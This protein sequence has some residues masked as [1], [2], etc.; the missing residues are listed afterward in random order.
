MRG[1]QFSTLIARTVALILLIV[2]IGFFPLNLQAIAASPY[3]GKP[4]NIESIKNR[5]LDALFIVN[6][7]GKTDLAFAGNYTLSQSSKDD[8]YESLLITSR[9]YLNQCYYDSISSRTLKL[10]IENRGKTYKGTCWGFGVEYVDMATIATP[11]KS[12]T[13][14]LW[15]S[16]MPNPGGWLIAVYYVPGFG[17]TFKETAV[18]IINKKTFVIG[19]EK[20]SPAPTG[21]ALVFNQD[22]SF[23]GVLTSKGVGTVPA[24]YF[25]VHGSPLQCSPASTEGS[26]ITNCSTRKSINES[27]QDGVWTIDETITTTPTPTPVAT[28]RPS[29]SPTN[30]IADAIVEARDA[31][32]SALNAYKLYTAKVVACLEAFKGRNASERRMLTIVAGTQICSSENS[33]A[34]TANDQTLSLGQTISSSR[35]PLGLIT[36]FNNFTDTFNISAMAMDDAISMAN[37]LASLYTDFEGLENSLLVF[38]EQLENLDYVLSNLPTRVTALIKKGIAFDYVEENRALVEE[39]ES[40]F[41]EAQSEINGITYP[42]PEAIDDFSDSLKV[43]VRGLPS[44]TTFSRTLQRA[45]DSIPAFYCKKGTSATLPKKGKCASGFSRVKIDKG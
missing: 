37:K 16:Y 8:G 2:S 31:Y 6:Y 41:D 28:P 43:I 1:S 42:D 10:A 40:Q 4:T 22:G 15:D 32:S 20:F 24:E 3:A 7:G 27:A 35:D 30:S 26:A 39:A 19:V 9:D 17:V 29:P 44:E 33:T 18:G 5:I 36:Q 34:K 25:K 21:S 23:V 45:M 14:P 38:T 12:P 13:L 11:F